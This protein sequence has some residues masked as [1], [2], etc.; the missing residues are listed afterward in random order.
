MSF[1][2]VVV[3]TLLS[4]GGGSADPLPWDG[5]SFRT[6]K[7][8]GA[9]L[10]LPV[11]LTGSLVEIRHF[12]EA[13]P[14]QMTDVVVVSNQRGVLVELGVFRDRKRRPLAD[15]VRATLPFLRAPEATSMPWTA[16]REKVPALLFEQPRSGQQFARRDA[17]F[18]VGDR[19][20]HLTCLDLED[21]AAVA[22]F[23]AL[24]ERLEV[25]P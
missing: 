13:T 24:L 8:Q 12:P 23:E 10:S 18:R 14:A 16:T 17:V 7:D 22:V 6:L 3:A 2:A 21:R 1:A 4:G 9:R 15:F 5:V 11:P 19:V 20:V 25:Y